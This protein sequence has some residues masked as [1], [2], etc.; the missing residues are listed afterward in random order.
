M[1]VLNYFNPISIPVVTIYSSRK[2]GTFEFISSDQERFFRPKVNACVAEI[3][4]N[5]G[6]IECTHSM[7]RNTE[8]E[9]DQNHI[10]FDDFRIYIIQTFEEHGFKDLDF[11]SDDE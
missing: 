11:S 10:N 3:M 1:A 8:I 2:C 6:L 7:S 9:I 4:R 5:P